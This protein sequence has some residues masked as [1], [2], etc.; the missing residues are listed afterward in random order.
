MMLALLLLFLTVLLEVEVGNKIF[1]CLGDTG[2]E[3]FR[4]NGDTSALTLQF[5]IIGMFE[6]PVI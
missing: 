1:N 5:E 3:E 2:R 6:R 4:Y